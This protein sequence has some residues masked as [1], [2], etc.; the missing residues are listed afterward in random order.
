MIT[1]CPGCNYVRTAQDTAPAYQCPLCGVAY[2]NYRREGSVAPLEP[3]VAADNVTLPR[4]AIALETP[5]GKDVWW[6]QMLWWTAASLIL[7]S[8]VRHVYANHSVGGLLTGLLAVTL[9]LPPLQALFKERFGV[10]P[11]G[12]FIAASVFVTLMFQMYFLAGAETEIKRTNE[13]NLQVASANRVASVMKSRLDEF[14]INKTSI[15]ADIQSKYD[16]RHFREALSVASKYAA[17]SND[18]ELQ[19]IKQIS[20]VALMREDIK[21]ES[22]LS[23]ERRVQIYTALSSESSDYALKAQSLG[24]VLAEEKKLAEEARR[25]AMARA[26]PDYRFT[27]DPDVRSSAMTAIALSGYR[28][29]S[30]DSMSKL[31]TKP[32]VSIICDGHKYKYTAIDEGGRVIIRL[33]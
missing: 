3:K 17:V 5:N 29:N 27:D 7:F 8:T 19:S 21:G 24:R 20:D 26:A 6:Q 28:C 4:S 25:L 18:K 10:I 14:N 33:D 16:A 32:G 22:K 15:L 1:T 12:G 13:A 31:M 9:C 30:I 11:H 2:P 23:L